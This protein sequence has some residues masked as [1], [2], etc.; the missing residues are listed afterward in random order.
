[1]KFSLPYDKKT[2]DI[3]IDHRNFAGALESRV[4]SYK[5]AKSQEDLIEASLHQPIGSPTL[6]E[7]AKGKKTSLSS[8][9]TTLVL[10]PLR[11]SLPSCCGAS[12]KPNLMPI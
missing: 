8:A 6:E 12:V 9:L 3:E 2:I 11:S 1:M 10:C 7:L 4:E 5:P